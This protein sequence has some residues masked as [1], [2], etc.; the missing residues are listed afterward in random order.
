[1]FWV[2]SP[3]QGV[4]S[5][6]HRRATSGSAP[7]GRGEDGASWPWEKPGCDSV[8]PEDPGVLAWG[9][10]PSSPK[11]GKGD[12]SL[13]PQADR[14]LTPGWPVAGDASPWVRRQLLPGGQLRG[15]PGGARSSS[16]SFPG[17]RHLGPQRMVE[18]AHRG[19]SHSWPGP[20]GDKC[21]PQELG[22][23]RL[24]SLAEPEC[25][26]RSPLSEA[27]AASRAW[28]PHPASVCLLWEGP[29]V[30]SWRGGGEAWLILGFGRHLP[31]FRSL[32]PSASRSVG[33]PDG[34]NS[35]AAVPSLELTSQGPERGTGGLGSAVG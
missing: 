22:P 3:V 14:P 15:R 32:A 20:K 10:P 11:L 16:C 5:R 6:N 7:G 1:M 26:W 12:Q 27:A 30:N 18:A 25:C 8:S 35:V 33:L 21:K 13:R 34:G 28:P 23:M 19:D 2:S 24:G 9:G 17:G 4:L 29:P 31:A